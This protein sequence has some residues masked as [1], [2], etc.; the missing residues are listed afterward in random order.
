MHGV[1]GGESV[2]RTVKDPEERRRELLTCAMRLFAEKGYDNVS[3]R[4]VARDAGVTPGL[5]YHYFDSKQQLFDAAIEEYARRSA[6]ALC[7]IF[8]DRELT[9]DEQLDRALELGSSQDAF[10]YTAF[11]H[12]Q[13]NDALHD[14]LSLAMCETVRGHVAAS[15]RRD[16]ATRGASA[17]E[18][19]VLADIMV[20]GSIGI[21]SGPGMPDERAILATRRYF[22]ALLT[23]FRKGGVPVVENG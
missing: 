3:V 6:D 11:F 4:A 18:A 22:G 7:R 14:R 13:G 21:A 12:A 10:P 23:E 8:D 17:P 2:V 9:L 15:L 19:E 16:A 5:A 1:P 20:Y